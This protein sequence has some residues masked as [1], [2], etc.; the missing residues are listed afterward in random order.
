MGNFANFHLNKFWCVSSSQ[1]DLLTLETVVMDYKEMFCMK[2]LG[3]LGK[4]YEMKK[5]F[6]LIFID[7]VWRSSSYLAV[8]K[9]FCE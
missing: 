3:K 1:K 7:T 5:Y 6:F 8:T 9:I 2:Y 4:K